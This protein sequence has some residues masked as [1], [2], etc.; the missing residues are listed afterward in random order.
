MPSPD[1]FVYQPEANTSVVV[2]IAAANIAG[3]L[4]NWANPSNA[5]AA[6]TGAGSTITAD[7]VGV[8]GILQ[9]APAPAGTYALIN[10]AADITKFVIVEQ[11]QTNRTGTYYP[12]LL[13]CLM[14]VGAQ[15]GTAE[16]SAGNAEGAS[17]VTHTQTL[18]K[19]SIFPSG[20]TGSMLKNGTYGPGFFIDNNNIGEAGSVAVRSVTMQV[21]FQNPIPDDG[22]ALLCEA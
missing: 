3:S 6:G 17:F 21:F 8:T 18:L 20:I 11:S 5:L 16:V 12:G 19:A 7:G 2:P 10:D 13:C 1:Q 14:N 4:A 22:G 9:C 15:V